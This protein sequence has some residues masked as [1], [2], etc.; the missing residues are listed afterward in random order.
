MLPGVGNSGDRDGRRRWDSGRRKS[1]GTAV[2]PLKQG[3]FSHKTR[4]EGNQKTQV[5]HLRR[6]TVLDLLHHGQN[7]DAAHVALVKQNLQRGFDVLPTQ[8]QLIG[9]DLYDSHAAGGA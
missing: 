3:H 4:S 7:G 6:R 2:E 8:A 9:D 5:S 1:V